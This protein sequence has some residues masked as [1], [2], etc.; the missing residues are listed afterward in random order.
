MENS[1][2]DKRVKPGMVFRGGSAGNVLSVITRVDEKGRSAT[3]RSLSEDQKTIDNV[4]WAG[5]RWYETGSFEFIRQM[6]DREF[7]KLMN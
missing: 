3:V 4:H 7:K 1:I 2:L 5:F 6:S